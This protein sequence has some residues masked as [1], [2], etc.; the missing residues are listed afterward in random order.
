MNKVKRD[1]MKTYLINIF[2]LLL[3]LG[4]Y[5]TDIFSWF[6]TNQALWAAIALVIVMLLIGWKIIGNPFNEEKD[7]DKDE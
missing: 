4:A 1:R 3:I 2:I 6:A 5:Y 7:H